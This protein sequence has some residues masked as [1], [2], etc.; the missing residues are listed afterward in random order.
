[1]QAGNDPLPRPPGSPLLMTRDVPQLRRRQ[2]TRCAWL[3]ATLVF[4]ASPRSAA[5][6]SPTEFATGTGEFLVDRASEEVTA[7]VV[8]RFMSR[9]CRA[10]GRGASRVGPPT[11]APNL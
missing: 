5:A 1:M 4:A 6:Q 8:E 11:L 2:R 10:V 3:C 9:L 7:Y